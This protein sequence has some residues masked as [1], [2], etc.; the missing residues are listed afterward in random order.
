MQSEFRCS[1][2]SG[3]FRRTQALPPKEQRQIKWEDLS[4]IVGKKVRVVMPDGARI[5]GKAT[6]LEPDALAVDISRTTNK[7]AYPKGTFL[8]PRATLKTFDVSHPTKQW[9]IVCTAAGGALG[10]FLGVEAAIGIG[11]LF[12]NRNNGQAEGAFAALAIGAPILGYALGNAADRRTITYVI[13]P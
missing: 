13:A 1:S 12:G 4:A 8:V 6:R 7:A 11:G 3:R 2:C 9:R 10:L 5:E